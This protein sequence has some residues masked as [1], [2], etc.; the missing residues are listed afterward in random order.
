MTL[1]HH[2]GVDPSTTTHSQELGK[3]DRAGIVPQ[4]EDSQ[5]VVEAA[6]K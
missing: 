3:A 6:H 2:F 4:V 1:G 5:S